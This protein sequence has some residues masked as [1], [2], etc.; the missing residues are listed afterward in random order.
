MTPKEVGEAYDTITHLWDEGRFDCS[1]G[2]EALKKALFFL[3]A[4]KSGG[5]LALDVGCGRT[6]RFIGYLSAIRWQ[7]D[8]VDVSAK[9]LSLARQRHPKVQFYNEDICQWE[10]PKQYDFIIAWDSIWHVPLAEQERVMK[11]LIDGLAPHGVLLFSFGGVFERGEHVDSNMGP[12]VYYSSLGVNGFLDIL[13]RLNCL[14]RHLE[15]DQ[16]PSEHAY[17]IVEKLG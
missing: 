7:V 9:M 12:Q 5:K 2:I 6:G 3:E 11:K 17:L 4:R 10:L 14:C 16:Y 13:T 15:F 8:G 1:N